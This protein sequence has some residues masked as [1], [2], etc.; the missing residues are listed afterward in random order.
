[1]IDSKTVL[2]DTERFRA[3][4]SNVNVSENQ[5]KAIRDKYLKGDKT[6]SQWLSRV[7]RNI[8]LA[9][10]FY[11]E[12]VKEED[13]FDDVKFKKLVNEFD[14]K[15]VFLVHD[16]IRD[17]GERKRNHAKLVK[18]LYK[19]QNK[20]KKIKKLLQATEDKFYRMMANFEF[21]PNSPTL[22]NAG[23]ELQQL[24]ACYV[25]PVGD[26]LEEIYEA[27]TN[28]ALI[29]KS[30]GG[31]GFDFS[32]LRPRNDAVMTTKGVSSGPVS[33]MEL[34]DKS[35]DVI[36][37]GGTRRGANMGILRYDH[38]DIIEFMDSKL[39]EGKLENFNI[40]VGVDDEFMEAVVKD[41]EYELVNPRTKETVQKIN[42]REV[43]DKIVENAWSSADPGIVF[44][45]RLN[46]P[47]SNP[48][49]QLGS[50]VSTNPCGEQPLLPFE[51][52]N[53]GSINLSKFVKRDGSDF[54]YARL[55][56]CVWNA[57]HFLDNT[58][59]VNLFP[60]PVIERMTKTNRKIGLGVMGWA[61]SLVLLNVAYE[62]EEAFQKA[63][64]VMKFIN[65][66]AL[67]V[68][69]AL[70]ETRGVFQNFKNSVFDEESDYYAGV[71]VKPRN[72]SRTTIAPT[73]TIAIAA[74]VQ[75]AG[76]EPFFA[77]AYIRY[78]A[79]GI[80]ALK[81]GEKP[82]EADTF[83]EINPLF[84][85]VAKSY[86]F[87]GL[88]ESE[89]WN[90]I[91]NNHKSI[92]GI[93]EIPE[94]VQ[95]LFPTAH[96][97]SSEGHVKMQAAF[98]KHVN[99][100]VSKT[101][102]L[103]RE[104]SKNDVKKVY[105][106]SYKTGCKGITIYRDGSK[107][108]QIL[109]LDKKDVK[110]RKANGHEK[111]SYYK[112]P[113]GQGALHIHI[114]YDMEGPTRLFANIT[115]T[116]TEISGLTTTLGILASKYFQL[117]GNPS[118]LLRHFNSIKGDKP[119]GFGPN[120][121]DSIPHALSKALRDHLIKTGKLKGVDGQMTIKGSLNTEQL[122]IDYSKSNYCPN[123]FSPNVSITDGCSE[124]TCFDC[125]FS[126]CS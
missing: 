93:D 15:H 25:L 68:S 96:D 78:N 102:N 10:L 44:V 115:P 40:S 5:L 81:K 43:F 87:F 11:V 80:D 32:S 21:L 26:S 34:F 94:N 119:V 108:F 104:A 27:L 91:N 92:K 89:L 85:K 36:K 111:S 75:G 95:K 1:M 53:L 123:C 67:N 106:L 90:K 51:S 37:Q 121:I 12:A 56:D 13:V 3:D 50:I 17:Y 59:D 49:P 74:G 116:G 101:V 99:N 39:K 54:D 88:K 57:V 42:A 97:I 4:L 77:I 29:H 118:D 7:A 72:S 114:N 6:I 35:T 64:E 125:G 100:A 107:K 46:L 41:K 14:G 24:S 126:K 124:P 65:D 83:F 31:T 30:G 45:D 120:R 82:E 38:P 109:N 110:K 73:G 48:T 9:D 105:L 60:L 28:M 84:R 63:E 113:T 79:K 22:M 69:E 66:E 70:A 103:V 55:K 23:R 52:C 117:G 20:S 8:A 122:L 112:I 33:F 62:S 58:I 98:Q 2:K 16:G 47:E 86:D 61:E 76:I 71:S 19:L 18:N